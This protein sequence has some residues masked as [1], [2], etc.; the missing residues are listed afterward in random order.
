MFCFSCSKNPKLLYTYGDALKD[1]ADCLGNFSVFLYGT[2]LFI[3]PYPYP[4][5]LYTE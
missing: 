2:A 3:I 4:V 1:S 5:Y